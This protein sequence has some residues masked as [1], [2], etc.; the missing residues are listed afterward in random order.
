MKWLPVLV[1]LLLIPPLRS[2]A[3]APYSLLQDKASL[4]KVA[5]VTHLIYSAEHAAARQQLDA[6]QGQ[7]PASHPVFP[8]LKAL[9]LYYKEAPMHTGSAGFQEFIALLHQTNQQSEAYLKRDQDKTMITFLTLTAHSL[10]TR[11]HAEKG[12]YMT[13][14]KVAKPTYGFM[15]EGFVLKDTYGE[16]NF[17]VGVYNY[18]RVKY[19]ELHPVYKPFMWLFQEG[20]KSLGLLQMEQSV[21]QNLFTRAE[22]AIFLVHIYLYYENQPL[23]ALPSI[24]YLYQTYPNNRFIR[25][26]LA[27]T[28]VSAQRYAEAAP[29]VAFLLSLPDNYYRMAGELFS[30]MIQEKQ[31]QNLPLAQQHYQQALA[32]AE[33]LNYV[34][35]TYRSM[36]HAGLGRFYEASQQKDKAKA[37]WQ[38]ALKLAS[39]E[40]PVKQEAKKRVR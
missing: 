16:F 12:E 31:H 29:H 4:S 34:A 21:R 2:G 3:Q 6:L 33:P 1:L 11:Y 23:K 30:G 19:P 28:L 18:Y 26:Q 40:Y 37:S 24:F 5:Q 9:N 25:L 32:L 13:A 35:D 27:E 22:A 7:I 17:P 15:K 36:A 39:Y 10:L 20:D 38:Q 8:L 14:I